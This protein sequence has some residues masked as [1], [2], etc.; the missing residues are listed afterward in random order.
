MVEVVEYIW[1]NRDGI[2]TMLDI[3][4]KG[5]C[6]ATYLKNLI[7]NKNQEKIYKDI[8]KEIKKSKDRLELLDEDILD[9][10]FIILE[11][12]IKNEDFLARHYIEIISE[13]SSI[14]FLIFK[15]VKLIEIKIT[16]H[17]SNPIRD[18]YM[19]VS[20]KFNNQYYFNQMKTIDN[21]TIKKIPNELIKKSIKKLIDLE[22]ISENKKDISKNNDLYTELGRNLY[23]ASIKM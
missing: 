5:I 20:E 22:L 18:G 6:A 17:V 10:L 12:S 16:K 23:N 8:D 11:N 2:N 9:E 13:L 1:E 4:G 15:N 21:P 14:D 19:T 7:K 3:A